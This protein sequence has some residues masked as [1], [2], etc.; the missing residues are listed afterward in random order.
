MDLRRSRGCIATCYLPLFDIADLQH[1]DSISGE[2]KEA[3]FWQYFYPIH[4]L[5]LREREKNTGTKNAIIWQKLI[6]PEETEVAVVADNIGV[7]R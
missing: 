2:E 1:L 5:N 3:N 7:G 6:F 4:C